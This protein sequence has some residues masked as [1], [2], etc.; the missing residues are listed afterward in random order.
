MRIHPVIASVAATSLLVL[1]SVG[2]ASA[3]DRGGSSSSG[4][5]CPN[6]VEVK[7]TVDSVTAPTFSVGGVV[8]TT[9][10]TTKFDKPL[11]AVTDLVAGEMVEVK[12]T[13]QADG[14]VR[15]CSVEL[16]ND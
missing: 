12:T 11:T 6:K 13:L 14:S 4:S 15:A 8:I 10:A 2:I 5:K 1:G 3:H 7:G 16:E 9:D